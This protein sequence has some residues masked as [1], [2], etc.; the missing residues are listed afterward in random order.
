MCI[1]DRYKSFLGHALVN[2]PG[3][4]APVHC[5]VQGVSTSSATT[6]GSFDI[7][8]I[9][10]DNGA[11]LTTSGGTN[12]ISAVA[13]K[14]PVRNLVGS[15]TTDGAIAGFGS[16]QLVATQAQNEFE[17]SVGGGAVSGTFKL[18]IQS[19]G[20]QA[21]HFFDYSGNNAHNPSIRLGHIGDGNKIWFA[22]E[23][24]LVPADAAVTQNWAAI[25][26]QVDELPN[27]AGEWTISGGSQKV[28]F[29]RFVGFQQYLIGGSPNLDSTFQTLSLIHI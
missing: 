18:G 1:R 7:R 13:T 14:Q 24:E 21:L 17:W 3:G 6:G 9:R 8:F 15:W 29:E 11:T 26:S 16:C 2:P 5:S 12:P 28:K 23:D 20:V 4:G 22:N 19:H 25:T 10:K 27:L